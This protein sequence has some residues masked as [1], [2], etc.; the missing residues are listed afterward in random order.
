MSAVRQQ[1]PEGRY[2]RSADERADRKL[3]V[4]GAVLGV[5]LVAMVGWFG[6]D[7]IAG[8]KISAE[9][10]KF[11]VAS[12]DEVQVHLEVRKDADATGSCVV[13]SRSEEG[14][15]VGR[16]EVPVDRP[17]QTRIDRVVKVRTT[18][19]ATSAELVGCH[20]R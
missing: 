15:E 11:D 1:L 9:I 4:V 17:G 5:G 7:Y 20:A 6:Y 18:A 8:Q 3:K 19:Q 2:G 12:A 16:L 14:V 13:R 10:I